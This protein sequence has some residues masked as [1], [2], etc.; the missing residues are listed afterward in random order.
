MSKKERS[1]KQDD[2]KVQETDS[3]IMRK[4]FNRRHS[5]MGIDKTIGES[6]LGRPVRMSIY[7]TYDRIVLAA[8]DASPAAKYAFDC[9]WS[10]SQF[11]ALSTLSP[12]RANSATV[13]VFGDTLL[14]K[15]TTI[16]ASADRLSPVHTVTEN[17]DCRRIRRQSPFSAIRRFRQQ[18]VAI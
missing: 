7:G 9:K 17:G 12:K 3:E 4:A 15:S 1:K 18:I 8:I 2:S 16:V 11:K 14:P 10:Q 5:S 6:E 13:A